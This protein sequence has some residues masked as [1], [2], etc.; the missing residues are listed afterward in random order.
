M[1]DT[2]DAFSVKSVTRE[3]RGVGSRVLFEYNDPLPDDFNSF[4]KNDDNKTDLNKLISQ[5]AI[6][7]TSCT[8]EGEVYVTCGKGVRSRSDGNVDIMRWIDGV[9]EEDDNRIVIHIA[10][11]I[12]N[13]ITKIKLRTVDTDVIVILLAFMRQFLE[14]NENAAFGLILVQV[15][16]DDFLASMTRMMSLEILYV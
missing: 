1:L 5:L 11:M 12:R 13:D 9:H 3:E 15:T 7:P 6:R 10:D 8:W 14:L 2:Y 4:L 16:T